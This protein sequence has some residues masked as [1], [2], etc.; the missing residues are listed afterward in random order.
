MVIKNEDRDYF[1]SILNRLAESQELFEGFRPEEG[2]AL[3][4]FARGE[5]SAFCVFFGVEPG[6][7]QGMNYWELRSLIC[8]LD[9]GDLSDLNRELYAA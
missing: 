8:K 7:F 2:R 4:N 3:N 6:K 5:M 1:L 9:E